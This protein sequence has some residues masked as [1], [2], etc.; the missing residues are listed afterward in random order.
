[1]NNEEIAKLSQELITAEE[2]RT[3]V[4]PLT[5]RF[6]GITIADAY[7]IQLGIIKTKLGR[8]DAI[9]GKK[10]GLTSR[11]MQEMFNVKEAD[12]GH[13]LSSGV[14]LEGQPVSVNKLIQ[15]RL[16]AEI[17]FIL[18]NDLKG[19]GVTTAN[20]LA[21]T[22]GVMPA[23]EIIDSRIK[24]W[25][26]KIQDTIADNASNAAVVMGGKLTRIKDLD[27]RLIGMV[28]EKNGD[29]TATG[30]G[31]AVLGNPA[32]AVAWLANTLAQYG[33]SLKAGEFIMAGAL[34][35]ALSIK[36]GDNF[37]ASFD[38]LG[39]VSVRFI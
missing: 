33:I 16:E 3:P 25:K 12:Y 13:L 9:V 5:E 28:Y 10:I 20:V 38:R 8:G 31:A 29:I 22:E 19:P 30:A 2:T 6:P 35:A 27:L 37:S 34:T 26:I 21:A 15:P 23:F 1:M 11:A 18:K 14:I 36:A 39:A 17:C 7:N 4:A 24:D 32:Q